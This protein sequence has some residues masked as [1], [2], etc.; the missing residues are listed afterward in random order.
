MRSTWILGLGLKFS[1]LGFRGEAG[2]LLADREVTRVLRCGCNPRPFPLW[3]RASDGGLQFASIVA[4][5]A[6]SY[7]NS[8]LQ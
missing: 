3:L 5:C 2:R 6:R 8:W 4:Q 1:G 7:E